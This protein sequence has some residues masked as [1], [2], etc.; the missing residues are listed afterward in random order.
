MQQTRREP[1][2]AREEREQIARDLEHAAWRMREIDRSIAAARRPHD[3]RTLS[4]HEMGLPRDPVD[5][6]AALRRLRKLRR[7]LEAEVHEMLGTDRSIGLTPG[8]LR[9]RAPA[10]RPRERRDGADVTPES[11]GPAD[12]DDEPP[13]PLSGERGAP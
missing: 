9:P 12:P 7:E 5:R 6:A 4:R 2:T 11:A 1:T 10:A 8:A 13:A 3:P